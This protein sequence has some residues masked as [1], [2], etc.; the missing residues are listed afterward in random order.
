M[1]I[2]AFLF[3][4]IIVVLT[5]VTI[6]CVVRRAY[7]EAYQYDYAAY[8]ILGVVMLEVKVS[9]REATYEETKFVTRLYF[10]FI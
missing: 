6:H 8:D 4:S 2:A 10:N 7:L 1:K 9:R 5:S 3:F